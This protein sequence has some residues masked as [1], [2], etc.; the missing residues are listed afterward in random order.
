MPELD[1]STTDT[2]E[3]S[4]L[5]SAPEGHGPIYIHPPPSYPALLG[6]VAGL[7]GETN[8]L[9][10]HFLNVRLAG[11]GGVHLDKEKYGEVVGSV[12]ELLERTW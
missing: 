5:P 9:F 1:Q 8:N 4:P 2:T 6:A 12:S 7:R 11:E 10:S 3:K